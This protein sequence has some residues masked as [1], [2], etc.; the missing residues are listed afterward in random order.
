MTPQQ[1]RERQH[2]TGAFLARSG[3]LWGT[4]GGAKQNGSPLADFRRARD[5]H[6]RFI[7]VKTAGN[8]ERFG[9]FCPPR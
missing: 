2:S 7:Q 4:V 8:G 6:A 5:R 1:H 9:P 3:A